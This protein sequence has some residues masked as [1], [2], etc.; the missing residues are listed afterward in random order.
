MGTRLKE[1]GYT[2]LTTEEA[3]VPTFL[4]ML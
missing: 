3:T 2:T 4:I 1:R